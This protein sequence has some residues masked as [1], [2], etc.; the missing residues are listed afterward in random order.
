MFLLE[1]LLCLIVGKKR[2]EGKGGQINYS[3]LIH[4]G[5]CFRL[6]FSSK[7]QNE[8]PTR[9]YTFPGV[10]RGYMKSISWRT[11]ISKKR[12][13]LSLESIS[14]SNDSSWHFMIKVLN[15]NWFWNLAFSVS[16]KLSVSLTS[17]GRNLPS[18][19]II[20]KHDTSNE[21]Q[22]RYQLK[23]VQQFLG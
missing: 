22:Q 4:A 2:K 1:L 8:L 18:Q 19:K 13:D 6:I 15:D 3:K 20:I 14:A 11:F 7:L 12:I 17:S 16:F 23:F 21:I 5:G 9:F 10:N